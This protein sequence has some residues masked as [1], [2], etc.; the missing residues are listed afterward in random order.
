MDFSRFL[1]DIFKED[2]KFYVF[3]LLFLFILFFITKFTLKFVDAFIGFIFLGFLVAV[4]L[5]AELRGM[6][7]NKLIEGAEYLTNKLG[8]N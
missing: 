5:S 7:Q 6:T 8:M 2:T 4:F 3:L 1:R